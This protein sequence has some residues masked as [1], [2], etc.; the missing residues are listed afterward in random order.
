MDKNKPNRHLL[1]FAVTIVLV[2]FTSFCSKQNDVPESSLE[3]RD[4]LIYKQGSTIPFNGREKAKVNDKIIEYDVVDG[5]R[6]GDFIIYYENGNFEIKGQMDNGINVG[7]WQYFYESGELESEGYFVNDQPEGKWA[8]YSLS[9]N[10]IEEGNYQQ[11]KRVGLWRNFDEYGNVTL[12]K[13]FS[14]DDTTNT[15]ANFFDRFNIQNE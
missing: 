10:I 15:T 13:E 3:M 8:W 2:Y 1:T 11:G 6:H 7:K 12:E 4:S 9:G 5:V 14:L